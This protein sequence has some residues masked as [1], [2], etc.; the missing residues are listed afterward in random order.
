MSEDRSTRK[1][2]VSP[3]LEDGQSV[4]PPKKY[5]DRSPRRF[6]RKILRSSAPDT[7]DRRRS[8][9]SARSSPAPREPQERRCEFPLTRRNRRRSISPLPSEGHNSRSTSPKP[10]KTPQGLKG[11]L[12]ALGGLLAAGL[13]IAGELYLKHKL[14]E[15][16]REKDERKEVRH[17]QAMEE[18]EGERRW[19][20]N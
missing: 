17:E 15:H 13:P 7:N 6:R 19:I 3:R 8:P 9:G 16:E 12:V 18:K 1:E 20:W 10:R 11:G 4:S 2:E 14:H 5:R